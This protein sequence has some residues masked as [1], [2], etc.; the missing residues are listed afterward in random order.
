MTELNHDY[1]SGTGYNVKGQPVKWARVLTT[2]PAADVV[3]GY[4]LSTPIHVG[5]NW[6]EAISTVVPVVNPVYAQG[7][8]RNAAP[9]VNGAERAELEAEYDRILD[10]L[11]TQ[12]LQ[13]LA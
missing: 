13:G 10:I 1:A 9:E 6:E 4:S 5:T 11:R 3:P 7:R 8:V 2:V 12:G